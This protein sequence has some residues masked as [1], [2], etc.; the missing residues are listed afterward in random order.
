MIP[1][2]FA[3]INGKLVRCAKRT[4]GCKG[5]VFNDILLC[6]RMGKNQD[7]SITCIEDMLIFVKP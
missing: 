6:P 1:G 4:N 5:C 7:T 2:R 3:K